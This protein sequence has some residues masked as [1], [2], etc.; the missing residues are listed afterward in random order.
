MKII[1]TKHAFERY[2]ERGRPQDLDYY[3][4]QELLRKEADNKICFLE[5][6]GRPAIYIHQ[7]YWRYEY[8]ALK[9][10]VTLITCLGILEMIDLSKWSRKNSSINN[11]YIRKFAN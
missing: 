4:L 5:W 11:R 7:A 9:Q 10:E 2:C 6:Q 1:L 8:I 3:G